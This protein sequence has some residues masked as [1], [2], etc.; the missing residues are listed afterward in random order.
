MVDEDGVVFKEEPQDIIG[1]IIHDIIGIITM[2]NIIY[3]YTM[4]TMDNI[5][6]TYTLVTMNNIIYT[7]TMVTMDN[8]IY[9]HVHNGN[10]G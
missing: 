6:Y 2:D 5:V 7:Y 9:I 1:H 4:V 10:H 8:I 3:T